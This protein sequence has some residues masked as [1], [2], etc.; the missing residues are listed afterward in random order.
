MS[1]ILYYRLTEMLNDR[2]LDANTPTAHGS[3]QTQ[4]NRETLAS[5]VTQRLLTHVAAERLPP[6]TQLPSENQLAEMFG[7]SRPVIREALRLLAGQG[8]VEILNGKGAVIKPVTGEALELFFARSMQLEAAA[9]TEV[10]EVRRPLE[11]QSARLAAE[12]RGDEELEAM[13]HT[14]AA[15]RRSLSNLVAYTALD[16]KLHIQIAQAARNNVLFHMIQSIRT[17]A[18]AVVK[19]GL[20]KQSKDVELE[21]VQVLHEAIVEA[22]R[23]SDPDEAGRAMEDHF[24]TA[25]TALIHKA[26]SA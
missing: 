4:L 12:R 10:M 7:V 18:A 9:V 19:Q 22:I 15:M 20:Q 23:R 13:K 2:R 11:V 17:A 24:D 3:M 8:V 21:Q 6:G 5:Q 25:L 16:V 26:H 1:T 14:L